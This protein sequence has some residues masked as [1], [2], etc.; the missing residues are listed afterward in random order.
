MKKCSLPR[1]LSIGGLQ[2]LALSSR[3]PLF[4]FKNLPETAK[5]PGHLVP[6][7]KW[8]SEV[9]N[10]L[11]TN[12]PL[13]NDQPSPAGMKDFSMAGVCGSLLL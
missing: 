6:Q 5:N 7:W 12:C 4:L 13:T 10:I 8:T 2:L 9:S 3:R 11:D 1:R